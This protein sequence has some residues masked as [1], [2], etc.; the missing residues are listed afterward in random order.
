MFEDDFDTV[1]TSD[2]SIN[3]LVNGGI[4]YRGIPAE[5]DGSVD[6]SN[7]YIDWNSRIKESSQSLEGGMKYE[8]YEVMIAILTE[9]NNNELDIL[10]HLV[11]NLLNGYS[12]TSIGR[13]RF[14]NEVEP[15]ELNEGNGVHISQMFFTV[16]Y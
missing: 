8:S 15:Q 16:F 3:A 5:D 9:D 7:N 12:S 10:R 2:P 11:I 13:I 14:E 6:W 1:I 4:W